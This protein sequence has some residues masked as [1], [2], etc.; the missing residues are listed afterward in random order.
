MGRLAAP[1]L[2][3]AH[4][5]AQ[6]QG[7]PSLLQP[8][9]K[10]SPGKAVSTLWAAGRL[11]QE[12]CGQAARSAGPMPPG[13]QPSG[14]EHPGDAGGAVPRR[15]SEYARWPV[16]RDPHPRVSLLWSLCRAAHAGRSLP[17]YHVGRREKPAFRAGGRDE[18][19]R[20]LALGS[21]GLGARASA[22]GEGRARPRSGAKE[23]EQ[24]SAGRLLQERVRRGLNGRT[25]APAVFPHVTL[26]ERGAP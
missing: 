8:E 20:A 10:L 11:S 19:T 5:V 13:R 16:P 2:P 25:A 22:R 23:E 12:P 3:T 1:A 18:G 17:L 4:T 26:P 7:R 15:R 9:V 24:A 6:T 21:V 14:W